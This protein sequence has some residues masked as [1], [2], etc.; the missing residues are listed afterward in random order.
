MEKPASTLSGG[1]DSSSISLLANKFTKDDLESFS[2]HFRGLSSNDFKKTDEAKF[3]QVVL[4]NSTLKHTHINLDYSTNGPINNPHKIHLDSQ[5][6]GIINGF[7]HESIFDECNK[8]NIRYLFDGLF[9]DEVISHGTFRL[10]ELVKSGNILRFLYELIMLRKN[11]VILSLRNQLNT[12]LL[13]P[14]KIYLN[15]PS[16]KDFL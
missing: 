15:N 2:V 4:N 6:Y 12:H 11:K 5:P 1:L 16:L 10:N 14:I 13:R 9:G 3:I 8:R 7:L